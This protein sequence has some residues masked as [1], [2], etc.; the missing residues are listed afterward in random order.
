[1]R[2]VATLLVHIAEWV[3]QCRRP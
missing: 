2:E 3:S 1:M